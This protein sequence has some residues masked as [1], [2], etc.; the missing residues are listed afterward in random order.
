MCL[1]ALVMQRLRRFISFANPGP[2]SVLYFT[3][4]F[5]N[6]LMRVQSGTR[7]NV[8]VSFACLLLP[9]CSLD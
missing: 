5:P 3:T 1:S 9:L 7:S 6:S 4:H 2:S 8:D